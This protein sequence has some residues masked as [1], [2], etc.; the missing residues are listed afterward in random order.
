MSTFDLPPP[1]RP[2][3]DPLDH[4]LRR[5]FDAQRR[6]DGQTAPAFEYVWQHARL[7]PS[8][9]GEASRRTWRG[10]VPVA[11]L[12]LLTLTSIWMLRQPAHL[13]TPAQPASVEFA[14]L[15]ES[16]FLGTG[17]W[18]SAPSDRLVYWLWAAPTDNDATGSGDLPALL[19]ASSTD[20]LLGEAWGSPST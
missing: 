4:D 9:A 10:T 18:G 14:T 6:H 11:L 1:A 3:A 8:P 2:A 5:Y 19:P 16:P 12:L 13:P 20:Y 17:L 15:E 7:S